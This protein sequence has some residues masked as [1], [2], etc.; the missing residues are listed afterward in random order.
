MNLKEK[1]EANECDSRFGPV[2]TIGLQ[3]KVQSLTSY[4]RLSLYLHLNLYPWVLKTPN[5]GS[6]FSFIFKYFCLFFISQNFE[7]SL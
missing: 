2:Q 1:N 5:K 4:P 6:R 3:K 7:F